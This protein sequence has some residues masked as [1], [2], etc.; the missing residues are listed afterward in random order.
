MAIP[1][2]P[3]NFTA[4]TANT[5]NYLSWDIAAGAVSYLIQS[6]LDGVNYTTLT[7]VVVSNYL[8][9]AVVSGTQYWYKVAAVNTSGISSY[10][11][12]AT[13]IP[14]PTAEMS[15]LSLR[16][17]SKQ[18]ADLVN[19]QFVTDSE[20]NTF[21]GLAMYELY[22]MLIEQE[23]ERFMAPRARFQTQLGNF[24]YPLPN[25]VDTFL[26]INQ[27]PYVAEP[28]Y[29]LL[30]MDLAVNINPTQNA[31]VTLSRYNL[32]DR[33]KFGYPSTTSTLYGVLNMQYRLMGTNIELIPPPNSSQTVQ[34]LYIP[35]L[36]QLLQD[37]DITTLGFSGWL[38]YV[39]V[40]AAKYALDK[41]E[42]DTSRLSEELAFIVKR[43]DDAS[44]DRDI[45]R[46]D[47]I[48]DVRKVDGYGNGLDGTTRWGW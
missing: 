12:P 39:I 45:G 16:Q 43:V 29:K 2:I 21:I 27:Q 6:S 30:G 38:Q 4:Q 13:V 28:F 23:S 47:T 33:N 48:S 32:I 5:T 37:T 25:G 17:A 46:P 18:K 40:R 14:A 1:S 19:S 20:W 24:M 9:E 15:L 35:R 11:A 26:D 42:S 3:T 31:F 34:I 36:P 10:T 41:E 7:S 44:S 22:D 8:D